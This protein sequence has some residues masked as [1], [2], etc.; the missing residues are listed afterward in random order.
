MLFLNNNFLFH[1]RDFSLVEVTVKSLVSIPISLSS[2]FLWQT[3][4]RQLSLQSVIHHRKSH[5]CS[6]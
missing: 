4:H 2:V 1:L 5:E 6:A 3:F